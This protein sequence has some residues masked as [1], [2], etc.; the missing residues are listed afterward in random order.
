MNLLDVLR[1]AREVW[2]G[3]GFGIAVT[4][5]VGVAAGL[6]RVLFSVSRDE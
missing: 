5:P 3:I 1:M 4:V 6:F 2:E